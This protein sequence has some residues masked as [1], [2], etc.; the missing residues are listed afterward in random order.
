MAN[1]KRL[2]TARLPAGPCDVLVVDDDQQL[3]ETALE[4]LALGGFMAAGAGN[5]AEAL[6]FLAKESPAL[7]LL[8][9]RM[10]VMDGWTFLRQRAASPALAAVP[11]VILSGEPS[12]P[13]LLGTVEGWISKP[14]TEEDLLNTVGGLLRLIH[15][16]K[17]RR[18]ARG[19]AV[20]GRKP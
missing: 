9:L 1:S 16:S 10:P 3:R 14:F 13:A 5:G 8:D 2:T 6:A 18:P 12:E 15:A 7:I 4:I 11:V 19:R 20:G 17:E